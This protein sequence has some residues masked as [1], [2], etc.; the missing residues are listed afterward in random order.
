MRDPLSSFD[1]LS[2]FG[3][4]NARSNV[5]PNS[6]TP[7]RFSRSTAALPQQLQQQQ[8]RSEDFGTLG[9]LGG[10]L[11][12]DVMLSRVEISQNET[13]QKPNPNRLR[14][15]CIGSSVFILIGLL[16]YG[17]VVNESEL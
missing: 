6:G 17:F 3:L 16:Y 1:T 4:Q 15:I 10:V 13:K 2:S 14:N 5:Q 7:N 11:S 8:Q 9:D 12:L